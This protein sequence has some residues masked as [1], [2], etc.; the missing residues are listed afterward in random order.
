VYRWRPT[1]TGTASYYGNNQL[2]S[3]AVV[4]KMSNPV[5]DS[6]IFGN[7]GTDIF[8][9]RYA[10]LLLNIAECYAAKGDIA[11]SVLYLGK[12]R[13]RVGIPSANNYGIGTLSDKYAA[14]EACLYERRVELAYEGKRFWDINA[15]CCIMM[16][17]AADNSTCAKLRIAPINGTNRTGYYWQAKLTSTDPLTA[18]DRNIAIDPDATTAAFNAEIAKLK[19][20]YSSKFVMTPLDQAMDRDGTTP[21]N[22][23]FR[24]NYYISGL[25]ATILSNNPWLTQ[26]IGWKDYNNATGTFTYR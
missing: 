1:A 3:P 26:T 6:T 20:L 24:Q 2:S 21:V 7:S 10:E 25:T 13:A 22:I 16:T 14:L 12:I 5:A 15:G 17:L 18:A 11:N 8:E 19:A 23:L 4:R 9:Y